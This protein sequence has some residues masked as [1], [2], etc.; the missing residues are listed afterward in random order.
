MPSDLLLSETF[1]GQL[2]AQQYR[3]RNNPNPLA[4]LPTGLADGAGVLQW[5]TGRVLV[6]LTSASSGRCERALPNSYLLT[7][8]LCRRFRGLD[9]YSCVLPR[10]LLS[11]SLC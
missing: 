9:N 10:I 6:S 11:E 1:V 8:W 5:A 4:P 2:G 7:S 3:F